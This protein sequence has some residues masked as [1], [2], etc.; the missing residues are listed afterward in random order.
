VT[1]G[2]TLPDASVLNSLLYIFLLYYNIDDDEDDDDD[3]PFGTDPDDHCESPLEAYQDIVPFLKKAQQDIAPSSQQLSIYDPYYCNG[4][5]VKQLESLGFPNVYN[6]KEDCY[7]VWAS[8]AEDDDDDHR[9]PSFD[10]LI[11]NPPYSGDHI[12][13]LI[14]H[15]TTSPNFN[16]RPWMLLLPQWVHKKDYY[17]R[18]T[19]HI[20]P[21]YVVPHKRYVYLPPPL[22]RQAKKSDVH[23]KSSP[24][25]SMWY[26]WGGTPHANDEWFHKIASS[27]QGL[28][29]QNCDVARS[30]SALRDLRRKRTNKK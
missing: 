22:F 11:T 13:R 3:F 30:R 5:V 2:L 28:V 25:V 20:Q 21:F 1:L 17:I 9:Y 7:Q 10:I 12:E 4:R 15:I 6:R 26:L 23:K 14:R 18:L 29:A 19:K 8:S 27:R 24:F 16:S